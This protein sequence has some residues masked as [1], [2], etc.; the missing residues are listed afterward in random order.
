MNRLLA[1]G[2]AISKAEPDLCLS[3]TASP[4]REA[5][6]GMDSVSNVGVRLREFDRLK[7]HEIQINSCRFFK[8]RY[9]T[10]PQTALSAA[11]NPIKPYPA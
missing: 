10:M 6:F 8:Y 5:V 11:H 2:A 7:L 9:K 4:I 3:K 1:S